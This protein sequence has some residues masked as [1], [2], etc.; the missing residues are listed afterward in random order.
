M[1][2][3][4]IFL[5]LIFVVV[6]A[7]TIS[8]FFVYKYFNS[9]SLQKD[10]NFLI[11]RGENFSVILNNLYHHGI[12]PK[13][14][15]TLFF[16]V[17]KLTSNK[18]NIK[19]GEYIF[20][21]NSSL[22]DILRQIETGK[23]HTRKITFAEGLTNDT[24]FKIIDKVDGLSGEL[25][26]MG[27][28]LEGTLLPETYSYIYGDTKVGILKRMQKAMFDFFDKEWAKRSPNLPF[29]TKQEALSLASI[30]EKETG[31]PNERGKVASVFVNR[32][33]KRMR[34]QSDPTVMYA[35]T[36]GNKDLERE[37]RKTDLENVNE[38]NTYRINGIPKKPIC[39]PG[40][41]AIRSTLNPEN[42]DYLYFVATGTGGHNFSSNLKDHNKFVKIYRS[43][44]KN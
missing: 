2:A 3:W 43:V 37:I 44:S 23:V 42:T 22:F 17:A 35:F 40:K 10:E 7:I 18:R 20:P 15:K 25:P 24:I 36:G 19:A 33:K 13:G 5:V 1:K 27:D 14:T 11:K 9:P 4:K 16:N 29:N 41:D 6:F 12:V 21:K 26:P 28:F 39:N 31:V 30:V 32:L 8:I 38:Y 34:L